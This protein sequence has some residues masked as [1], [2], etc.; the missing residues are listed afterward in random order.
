MAHCRTNLTRFQ[1]NPRNLFPRNF[2]KHSKLFTQVSAFQWKCRL[3]N[4]GHFVQAS[5][6]T[7]NMGQ[8]ITQNISG[9]D[10]LHTKRM[11]LVLSTCHHYCD[12]M[13]SA[14][15]SEITGVSIVH[16]TVCSDADQRKHQSSTSL[17]FVRGIQRSPV[18]S[19]HKGLVTWKIFPFD[20]VIMQFV[21]I[22]YKYRVQMYKKCLKNPTRI[23]HIR[24]KIS[25]TS[26]HR[27][28]FTMPI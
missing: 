28:R 10:R 16:S 8:W 5:T 15:A 14:M 4:G 21:I 22:E 9:C 23:S 3:R 24:S 11:D 19:P 27:F 18:N 20:D 7:L 13:I 1:L 6:W 25:L 17:A 26:L 12:V 2:D